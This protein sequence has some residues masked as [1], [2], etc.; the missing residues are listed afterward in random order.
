MTLGPVYPIVDVATLRVR[1]IEVADFARQLQD[2]GAEV[3]Q[4]RN[5]T[6]S[7]QEILAQAAAIDA[8]L[9]AAGCLRVMN[10]RADL[11]VLAGWRAVHVGHLDLTPDAVRLVFGGPTAG[12][13]GT[14]KGA[15]GANGGSALVG[16][17]THNEAQVVAA[18]AG[19]ADYV[20]IGPVYATATKTNAEPAVGLE[21][22][23]RAR[24]LTRKPLVAIGGITRENAAAVREAGAD[25]VAVI[26]GLFSEGEGV[27]AVL[28]DFLR[29][30]R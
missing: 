19:T 6:G 27:A 20:A 26:G 5:K 1:G 4:L 12:T 14:G 29:R 3:L 10:D 11:A 23:R 2:G 22:V 18:D 15:K 30:L 8:A 21:G 28:Q 9:G 24:A 16:V 7:P 25:T 17:S 13:T